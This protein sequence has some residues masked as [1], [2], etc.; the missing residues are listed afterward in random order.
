MLTVLVII[1]IFVLIG[2]VPVYQNR[3]TWGNAPLGG[4]GL[5]LLIVIILLVFHVL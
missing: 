1:L 3:G 5:V 2:G 4:L